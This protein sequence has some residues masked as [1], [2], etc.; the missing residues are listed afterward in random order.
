MPECAKTHL[1]QSRISKFYGEDPP[2]PLFK[3]REGKGGEREGGRGRE[4]REG[5]NGGGGEG[6]GARHGLRPPPPRDKLWIRPCVRQVQRWPWERTGRG[7]LLLRCICSAA[8]EA[9]G[10]LWREERGGAYRIATRT[11]CYSCLFVTCII[12]LADGI[13]TTTLLLWPVQK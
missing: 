5:R 2:D 8:R 3:G 10:R 6:R 13:T 4:G 11:A 7:K 9:L 12:C 1:Q